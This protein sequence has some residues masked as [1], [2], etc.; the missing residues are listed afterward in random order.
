MP[1]PPQ[2]WKIVDWVWPSPTFVDELF[3][4]YHVATE[5]LQFRDIQNRL[6]SQKTPVKERLF[7]T[8]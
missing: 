1:F 7:L 3:L 4:T 5:K 2:S 8:F 6:V